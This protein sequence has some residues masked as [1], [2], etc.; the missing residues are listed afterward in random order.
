MTVVVTG[1]AGFI[2]S[3]VVRGLNDRG[4]DDIVVVDHLRSSGK[5]KNLRVKNFDDF[6]HP[7]TFLSAVENGTVRP[8]TIIHMG[9][10]TDTGEQDMDFMIQNNT[11]YTRKLARICADKNIRLIFASSGSVYGDGSQGFSDDDALTPK[12]EPLN[13]YAYSKLLADIYGIRDG[14]IKKHVAL[15]FF[16]VFGPNEYHKG[17]MASVIW[18][19]YRQ[20]DETGGIKLFQSHK[21]G[22]GNGEQTRDFVYV[23]DVVNVILWFFDHPNAAGIYNLGTGKAR[24]YNALASALFAAVGKPEK[25]EYIPTPERYRKGYQYFTEADLTKLRKAG[26]DVPFA[27]L[28]ETIKDYVQGYLIPGEKYW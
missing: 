23:K 28:E 14:W 6:L 22:V 15:R 27:S 25:I 11:V 2:G 4:I 24:T 13:P 20:I 8:E 18:H 3:C 12:L 9:A 5:F 16:N 10:R 26:C 19:A 17:P 21:E 7:D 1:G